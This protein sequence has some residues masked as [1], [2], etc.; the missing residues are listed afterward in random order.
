MNSWNDA[1][2]PS[3]RYF[4]EPKTFTRPNARHVL[5]SLSCGKTRLPSDGKKIIL[6]IPSLM[7]A[8]NI[9]AHGDYFQFSLLN[10][11]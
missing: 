8:L 11:W 9:D 1:T 7:L 3:A 10:G 6:Q 2:N 4:A 5:K